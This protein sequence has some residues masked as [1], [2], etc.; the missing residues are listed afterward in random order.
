[1]ADAVRARTRT[2]AS[3]PRNRRPKPTTV[4]TNG[5]VP[6]TGI[7]DVRDNFAFVRTSGYLPGPD[8]IY[9]SLAQIKRYGL[10]PGDEITGAARATSAEKNNPLIRL[11]SVN[12]VAPD[13]ARHRPEFHQLTPLHP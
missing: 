9:V 11:D 1:M 8:D 6:V 7:L 3:S 12:G 10:R 2:G 4:D 5:L 13:D